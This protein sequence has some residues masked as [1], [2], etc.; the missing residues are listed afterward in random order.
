MYVQVADKF[1]LSTP[2]RT[3]TAEVSQAVSMAGAN[4]AR[5]E[6]TFFV[7]ANGSVSVS[8]QRSNDLENWTT[9]TGAG[10]S[11]SASSHGYGTCK[12]T[13]VASQYI[14]LRY[15]LEASEG[16]EEAAPT[17]GVVVLAA[18]VRTADL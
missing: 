14:R 17:D 8:V 5:V 16:G 18:G 6:V 4:A 2:P 11:V 3:A 9:I 1:A 7:V 13:A 10:T 12:V 15:D